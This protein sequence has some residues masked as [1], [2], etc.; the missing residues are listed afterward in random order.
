MKQKWFEIGNQQITMFPNEIWKIA[1]FAFAILFPIGW[2][3]FFISAGLLQWFIIVYMSIA[4]AIVL[5]PFF[6]TG[7]RKIIIDG[8]T[9]TVFRK[10][11][12]GT[13]KACNFSDVAAIQIVNV[14]AHY[15]RSNY[16][17][18]LT[19]KKNPYGRG[20]RLN[21]AIGKTTQQFDKL[22]N[23][24]IPFIKKLLATNSIDTMADCKP[25]VIETEAAGF[26][27]FYQKGGFFVSKPVKTTNLVVA[28]LLCSI[29]FWTM[30]FYI[31]SAAS[32]RDYY[33]LLAFMAAALNL[34]IWGERVQIDPFKQ[35]IKKSYLGFFKHTYYY[36]YVIGYSTLRH[37]GGITNPVDIRIE[38]NDGK[39]TRLITLFSRI[40]NVKK[41][42]L[43]IEETK[44]ILMVRE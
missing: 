44:R 2:L 19:F 25:N 41:L 32:K 10:S 1:G 29:G 17:Y 39:S 31:T 12:F 6:Y 26:K 3:A 37:I 36:H 42:Q 5:L 33:W 18:K 16:Y 4:N 22:E 20:I 23:I 24:A 13:S 21:T 14:A 30:Y 11:W 7:S 40:G 8:K 34:G 15:N 38:I 43:L 27:M 35:I 9:Q 28:I